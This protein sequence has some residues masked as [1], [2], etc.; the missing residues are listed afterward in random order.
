MKRPSETNDLHNKESRNIGQFE[1]LVDEMLAADKT[2]ITSYEE[3]MESFQNALLADEISAESPLKTNYDFWKSCNDQTTN[4]EKTEQAIATFQN[5][6][7]QYLVGAEYQ[8]YAKHFANPNGF[9]FADVMEKIDDNDIELPRLMFVMISFF[10]RVSKLPLEKQKELLAQFP[11]SSQEEY[12]CAGGTQTRLSSVMLQMDDLLVQSFNNVVSGA[13]Q[14]LLRLV[15]QGTQPHLASLLQKSLGLT[16]Q[17]ALWHTTTTQI[18]AFDAFEFVKSFDAK[19]HTNFETQLNPKKEAVKAIAKTFDE[20]MSKADDGKIELDDMTLF[21]QSTEKYWSELGISK[22]ADFISMFFSTDDD[23]EYVLK[24]VEGTEQFVIQQKLVELAQESNLKTEEQ[25]ND[26]FDFNLHDTD[27]PNQ[28]AEILK[29]P[30]STPYQ[31]HLALS[32]L[33]ILSQ[34]FA[35]NS[36]INFFKTLY[37]LG[38]DG[39]IHERIDQAVAFLGQF[40]GN[41]F[42]NKLAQEIIGRVQSN[43][44][45]YPFYQKIFDDTLSVKEHIGLGIPQ[46]FLARFDENAQV[47]EE[48]RVS[49]SA[50]ATQFFINEQGGIYTDRAKIIFYH[51]NRNKILELLKARKNELGAESQPLLISV[52]SRLLPFGLK[53]KDTNFLRELLT[54]GILQNRKIRNAYRIL[55]YAFDNNIKEMKEMVIDVLGGI[56]QVHNKQTLLTIAIEENNLKMAEFLIENRADIL[57]PITDQETAFSLVVGQN[58]DDFINLFLKKL[59][60]GILPIAL[61]DEGRFNKIKDKIAL[62]KNNLSKDGGVI[63]QELAHIDQ[64]LSNALEMFSALEALKTNTN[65]PEL[66]LESKLAILNFAAKNNYPVLLKSII[67]FDLQSPAPQIQQGHIQNAFFLAIEFSGKDVFDFLITKGVDFNAKNQDGDNSLMVAC[68]NNQATRAIDLL[69]KPDIDLS[70]VNNSNQ[71]F[72]HLALINIDFMYDLVFG[73]FLKLELSQEAIN[74]LMNQQDSA[75]N[76]PLH[77]AL[78]EK[79]FDCFSKLVTEQ[80]C[81]LQNQAKKTPFSLAVENGCLHQEIKL[82]FENLDQIGQISALNSI[83]LQQNDVLSKRLLLFIQSDDF[84]SPEPSQPNAV[85]AFPPLEQEEERVTPPP[86]PRPGGVDFP[87]IPKKGK[88]QSK[89]INKDL[90]TKKINDFFNQ[91]NTQVEKNE[92]LNKV[93]AF[94]LQPP[95]SNRDLDFN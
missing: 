67:D 37:A 74:G 90:V 51:P 5:I 23:F 38:E 33:W 1:T 94:Q 62:A 53:K 12:K 19:L 65:S 59:L 76:T 69:N 85:Q 63:N 22:G 7:A 2:R 42:A 68:R 57:S 77:N 92:L 16:S 71:N 52:E 91:P 14:D 93:N 61:L 88:I 21:Q 4:Q 43:K 3:L 32:A 36:P 44:N 50:F 26:I 13:T 66:Q 56:N 28:I 86:S 64:A 87:N 82:I 45:K 35:G 54:V 75:G 60:D 73:E 29:N 95:R 30:Q 18:S 41:D 83:L 55:K 70:A 78:L 48:D 80:N 10:D 89:E 39:E 58:N 9:L 6:L 34:D 84:P 17:D 31:K 15:Y 81:G 47:N 49:F 20:L 79:K 40:Q 27:A 72:L 24:K 25:Q 11:M 46:Y 8:D